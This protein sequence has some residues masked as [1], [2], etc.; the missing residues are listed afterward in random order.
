MFRAIPVS[1]K[2]CFD[3]E[4]KR[5]WKIHEQKLMEMKSKLSKERAEEFSF[6]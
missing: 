1:N 5:N 4:L 3:K 2:I 6:L